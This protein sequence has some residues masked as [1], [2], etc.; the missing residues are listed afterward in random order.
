MSSYGFGMYPNFRGNDMVILE[1]FKPSNLRF[2]PNNEVTLNDGVFFKKNPP[3]TA[4][5]F[6]NSYLLSS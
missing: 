6:F 4:M 1:I 5:F 3:K 2:M